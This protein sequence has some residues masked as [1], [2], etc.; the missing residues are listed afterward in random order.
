MFWQIVRRRA[1][2]PLILVLAALA[3]WKL[4]PRVPKAVDVG[5]VGDRNVTLWN[6]LAQVRQSVGELHYGDRVDVIRM[7]GAAAEVRTASGTLGWLADTR[8]LM[9]P[10]LWAQ[11]A[12]LLA[13]ARAMPVQARGQTKTVSNLRAKPGRDGKRIYQLLRGTPVVILQRALADAPQGNEENSSEEKS[14]PSGIQKLRQEDWFLVLHNVDT[15]SSEAKV[16][17]QDNSTAPMSR[18]SADPVSGG[19]RGMQSESAGAAFPPGPIAGWVLARFIEP[20]LPGPVR[21]Y[22]SSADLH[23]VAWFELSRVPDG[24]GGEAPQ[25]LVAGSRGGEGQACDFTMLRV[26]T[27]GAA[28]KRYETAFVESDL[29]G[30]LPIRVSHGAIGPE[31]QFANIGEDNEERKYVMQ[32]TA[33]RRIKE[34]SPAKRQAQSKSQKH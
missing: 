2:V 32:Q 25:Y 30:R 28:R 33:V 29:C 17:T 11:S 12:A 8:Q 19:T 20:D 1:I 6:T 13:Q 15:S 34:K 22:A 14:S 10:D 23:V 7:E 27:W 18:A 31:F 21:D 24:S 16:T 9:D 3:Y 5:Y 26:Y 4:H